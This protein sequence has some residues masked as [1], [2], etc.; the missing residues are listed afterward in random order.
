MSKTFFK[1]EIS[2]LQDGRYSPKDGLLNELWFGSIIIQD[3]L[4]GTKLL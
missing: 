3:C 2:E 4:K 1:I